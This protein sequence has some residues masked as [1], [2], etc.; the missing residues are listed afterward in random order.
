MGDHVALRPVCEAD[1]GLLERSLTDARV[2]SEF[3]WMGWRDPRLWRKRFEE[4]RCLG[5]DQSSLMVTSGEEAVGFVG[6]HKVTV[7]PFSYYWNMGI[8]LVPEFRGRGIGTA[9]QRAL[10]VY[11]FTHTTVNR[12]EAMTDRDNIPEQRALEKAGFTREGVLR[13]HHFRAGRW[14]DEV[15][16]SVLRNEVE[17]SETA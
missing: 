16:Y 17:L 1:L 11:L 3:Q 6:W 7:S 14:R 12:V 8:V 13:G 15:V 10:V 4:N 9:A 2:G 5:E